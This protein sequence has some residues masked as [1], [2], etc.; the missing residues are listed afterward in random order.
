MISQLDHANYVRTQG[1]SAVGGLGM[2]CVG[3]EPVREVRFSRRLA[4]VLIGRATCGNMPVYRAKSCY[5]GKIDM[6]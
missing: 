1:R 2:C 5:H 3:E 6:L 4:G